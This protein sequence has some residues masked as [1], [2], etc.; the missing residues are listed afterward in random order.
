MG[1]FK[2]SKFPPFSLSL[3]KKR[4][5]LAA[6]VSDCQQDR[7]WIQRRSCPVVSGVGKLG[8]GGG[9]LKCV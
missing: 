2:L 1:V 7:V 6:A 5:N 4:E 9:I 3:S 8:G